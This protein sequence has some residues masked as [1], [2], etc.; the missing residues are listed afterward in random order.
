MAFYFKSIKNNHK[1]EYLIH[2]RIFNFRI[3]I[4]IIS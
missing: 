4:E 1:E 3:E 2:V